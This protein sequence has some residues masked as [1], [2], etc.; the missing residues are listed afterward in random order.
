MKIAVLYT[1]FNRKAH[2]LSSLKCLFAS[3]DYYNN[4][5]KDKISI[6]VYLT[7]DGCTDGT[8]EAIC[9][10]YPDK[11]IIILKGDGNL[12]WA[13]G[14]RLAWKEALKRQ[15]EWDFYLL[16][17][18]DTELFEDCLEEL[19]KTHTFCLQK[20]GKPGLYSGA[21]CAKSDQ[22]KTTYGGNI[23]TNRFLWRTYRVVPN[24][25]PQL[26]DT[27]NANI[28]MVSKSAVDQIGIF[29]KGYRHGNADYDYSMT[30]RS[31]GIPV[32]VTGSFCGACEDDHTHGKELKD[33]IIKMSSKERADYFSNPL[34]S[35][36]DY[37]TFIRRQVPFKYPLTWILRNL[38]E[39]YAKFY[40]MLNHG[41]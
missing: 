16:I 21:T 18:D 12:Y 33:K 2:T 3:L 7:D 23:I 32:Y 4:I 17:N 28:L 29:Y 11:D 25:S 1:C 41:Q 24:G 36:K 37:L 10:V 15:S 22:G 20:Q 8:V 14:M 30:A 38:H 13:G 35:S 6:T 5:A 39:K 40:Y 27:S 26:I 34:H 9:R 31:H 19:L